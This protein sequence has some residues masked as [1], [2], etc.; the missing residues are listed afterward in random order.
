MNQFK[1][2]LIYLTFAVFLQE[3]TQAQ[4]NYQ[5]WSA[6][7][8]LNDSVSLPF[9]LVFN[10]ADSNLYFQNDKQ[11]IHLEKIK[12]NDSIY[13]QFNAY[14]TSLIVHYNGETKRI[15]GY[16]MH[17][18]KCSD[19]NKVVFTAQP[20]DS[21]NKEK[22]FTFVDQF[23][24][25][26]W[27]IQFGNPTK[28]LAMGIFNA[29]Q[30]KINGYI[31]SDTGD[32]G[33]IF[34]RVD[35]AARVHLYFF[36]GLSMGAFKLH[37]EDNKLIGDY[38][39]GKSYHQN[40]MAIKDSSFELPNPS[41]ITQV[42]KSQP[43]QFRKIDLSN[44][45][46]SYP[47]SKWENSVVMI[48]LFGSWCPNCIDETALLKTLY[49]DYHE[50]GFD[51]IGIGYEYPKDQNTQLKRL[52]RYQ[53]KFDLPYTIL[54]GGEASKTLASSQFPM[55]SNIHAFPTT[56]LINRS[57]EIIDVHSGYNGPS[58]G[59]HHENY[60]KNIRYKIEEALKE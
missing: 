26:K 11:K 38:Y 53:E 22:N 8:H 4:E 60:V 46:V 37:I 45:M 52:K 40:V 39:Y 29:S 27:K 5:K 41:S 32:F 55:L 57:G 54:L 18:D 1:H 33:Y 56:I 17:P 42:I 49:E 34:G 31:L 16:W 24:T 43:I 59:W 2:V 25:N 10:E 3:L 13:Y 9:P 20:L 47:S 50:D 7:F 35:T 36:N 19:N 44:N 14:L 21:L 12:S 23:L 15:N 30:G 58:T 6:N 51:I 48:Q 28:R